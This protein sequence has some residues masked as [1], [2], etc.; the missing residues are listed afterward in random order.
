MDAGR[1]LGLQDFARM[2]RSG[3][4]RDSRLV[5]F[6]PG[7]P[8]CPS[9]GPKNGRAAVTVKSRTIEAGGHHLPTSVSSQPGDTG[10]EAV[11]TVPA[12]FPT[13][14]KGPAHPL[15]AQRE[16]CNHPCLS[17][18]PTSHIKHT[19][20][21]CLFCLQIVSEVHPSRPL[22]PSPQPSRHHR[23]PGLVPRAS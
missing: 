15:A 21:S 5:T 6:G 3:G 11:V 19:G 22:R 8:S 23:L 17:Q 12:T 7:A 2:D 4:R 20:K 9:I 13:S 14:E 10:S 1:C 16:T 18:T